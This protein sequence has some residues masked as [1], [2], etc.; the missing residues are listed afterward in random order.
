MKLWQKKT[1]EFILKSHK[2]TIKKALG[3][4]YLLDHNILLK[5]ARIVGEYP[6]SNT[7]VEIGSGLGGLTQTF[8]EENPH[9]LISIE[10]DSSS[11][12]ILQDLFFNHNYFPD[13]WKQKFHLFNKD[14]RKF[15]LEKHAKP[16]FI[17]VGNLP[18]NVATFIVIELLEKYKQK[19]SAGMFMIQKEVAEKILA[20][21]GDNNYG[22]TS[23]L[24]AAFAQ[25]KKIAQIP[26]TSF[27]P[28]PKVD[29]S[30]IHMIPH[31]VDLF[32]SPTHYLAFKII[33]KAAFLHRR[34]QILN[35]IKLALEKQ[36]SLLANADKKNKNF[37]LDISKVERVMTKYKLQRGEDLTPSNYIEI[38]RKVVP[39]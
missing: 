34:K 5:I 26:P 32:D 12:S 19:M 7:V 31:S 13:E 10:I 2:K 16:P 17:F 21:P 33:I 28:P 36:S 3:Q 29:S 35:S 6:T 20:K 23:V 15:E 24:V 39:F 25:V 4:N 14:I 27:Y 11:C 9:P 18:Y 38:S 22:L 30:L 37:S 1:I 8:L